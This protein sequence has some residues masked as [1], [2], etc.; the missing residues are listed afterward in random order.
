MIPLT[1]HTILLGSLHV[2]KTTALKYKCY[3]GKNSTSRPPSNP[4]CFATPDHLTKGDPQTQCLLI[5][6]ITN[7][8][9]GAIKYPIF[10]GPGDE[11][12]LLHSTLLE[13]VRPEGL[14]FS[15]RLSVPHIE[16]PDPW[17]TSPV[18]TATV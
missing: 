14:G 3:P 6:K 15:R 18:S 16:Q 7:N 9:R 11:F 5:Y 1:T 12:C 4:L 17:A 8:G 2:N 13:S 10:L